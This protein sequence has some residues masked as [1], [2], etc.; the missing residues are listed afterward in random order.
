MDYQ[1]FRDKPVPKLKQRERVEWILTTARESSEPKV[2]SNTFIYDFRI[3]RISAHIFNMRE[4]LWEIETIK[5]NNEFF[6]KLLLTPQEILYKLLLTPQ[7]ILEQAK[8][9][10]T[11]EQTTII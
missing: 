1:Y 4:D 11:Y 9:G 6:Y 5:E 8:K 2:S 3:P 7:E 10:Q